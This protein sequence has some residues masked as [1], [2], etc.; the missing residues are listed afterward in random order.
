MIVILLLFILTFIDKWILEP[1]GYI[2]CFM[3]ARQLSA[4]DPRE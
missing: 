4:F 3:R 2:D 1:E